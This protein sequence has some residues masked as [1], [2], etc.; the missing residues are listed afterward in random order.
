MSH[1]FLGFEKN[2]VGTL[3][4]FHPTVWRGW[5]QEETHKKQVGE[6]GGKGKGRE[7]EI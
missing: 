3:T 4:Y 2:V 5:G 6:E 1:R 7:K